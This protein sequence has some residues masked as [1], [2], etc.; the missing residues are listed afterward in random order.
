MTEDNEI[1]TLEKEFEEYKKQNTVINDERDQHLETSAEL[2]KFVTVPHRQ[3]IEGKEN[4][5]NKDTKTANLRRKDVDELTN[6]MINSRL[7][8]FFTG[9]NP[10][11]FTDLL[12]DKYNAKLVLSSSISMK[13]RE[14][15]A[16][17]NFNFRRPKKSSFL[18]VFGGK[19]QEYNY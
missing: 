14:L 3:E 19:K 5:I 17:Q 12:A 15:Q 6:T 10:V 4:F 1:D 9:S 2:S 11:K 7:I 13:E 18:N 8:D 16:S